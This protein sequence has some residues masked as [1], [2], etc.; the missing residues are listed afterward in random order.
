[1]KTR[2][3]I[4][5]ILDGDWIYVT[6]S[7]GDTLVPKLYDTSEAAEEIAESWRLTG[8]EHNVRVVVYL[9]DK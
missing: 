2:Y 5:V 4:Q 8:K 3:A 9:E 6:E 1:M 7:W